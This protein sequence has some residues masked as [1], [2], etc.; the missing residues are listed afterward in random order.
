MEQL[1][2]VDRAK[3]TRQ[4]LE[5]AIQILGGQAPF[6]S[7]LGKKQGN[8][9]YWLE[10]GYV[11]AEFCPTIERLTT[12]RGQPV[13][14]EELHP[15]VEWEILRMQALPSTPIEL[16]GGGQA[17]DLAARLS[18]TLP[19]RRAFMVITGEGADDFA[20]F[21]TSEAAI[22]FA[23]ARHGLPIYPMQPSRYAAR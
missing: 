16:P 13:L 22:Q 4:A 18:R 23:I 20:L 9:S 1:S 15:G 5:R 21:K 2:S 14:C 11:S 3:Q 6:A 10:R 12:D 8:V 7:A 17:N 19:G